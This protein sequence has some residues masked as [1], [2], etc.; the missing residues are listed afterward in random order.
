MKSTT[1]QTLGWGLVWKDPK[2]FLISTKFGVPSNHF[3]FELFYTVDF[4]Q[5]TLSPAIWGLSENQ[6]CENGQNGNG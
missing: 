3:R 6:Q 5:P 4:T 1:H 2:G